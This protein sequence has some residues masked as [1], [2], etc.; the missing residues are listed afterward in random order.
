MPNYIEINKNLLFPS[1]STVGKIVV[2]VNI[3]NQ[4]TKTD[5]NGITTIIGQDWAPYTSS[6]KVF[7]AKMT[8]GGTGAPEYSTDE[9]TLGFNPE[10]RYL[11]TANYSFN[12][13]Q[14][15]DPNKI[16][17]FIYP[18]LS[19][20]ILSTYEVDAQQYNFYDSTFDSNPGGT[21]NSQVRALASQPDGKVIVGGTF[22][23]YGGLDLYRIAR[24]DYNGLVD[25]SFIY[26]GEGGF[27]DRVRKIVVQ[28]DGKILVGGDFNSYND[29]TLEITTGCPGIARLTSDGHFDLDFTIGSGFTSTGY[30]GNVYD[31]V[32]QPDGK[33]LVGGW[34][35]SY[36]GTTAN[37][38]IRLDASGSEDTTFNSG[39]GFSNVNTNSNY[40]RVSSI[41]LQPDGKITCAGQFDTY[42]N[43]YA[44][45]CA[46]IIKLNSSG[47]VDTTFYNNIG[48]GFGNDWVNVARLQDDGKI[49]VGL[50][51]NNAPIEYNGTSIEYLTRLNSNGTLDTDF[52]DIIVY[53]GN[54]NGPVNDT[55]ILTSGQIVSAGGFTVGGGNGF[56]NKVSTN[57]YLISTYNNGFDS[58]CYVLE[59]QSYGRIL[60]GGDFTYFQPMSIYGASVTRLARIYSSIDVV[61]TAR[62]N[63]GSEGNDQLN[64]TPVEI[65]Q[66][67]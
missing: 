13:S 23:Q 3:A 47:S 66:Y 1:A 60:V 67:I 14:S 18:N 9:N 38:I 11:T 42:T 62:N 49:V 28:D 17:P 61:L 55:K 46:G 16:V 64:N 27:N 37:R 32:V 52:N 10:W 22:T 31:I 40:D 53:E 6:Y 15:V 33:I 57:G 59:P 39:N 65:R 41:A 5:S 43:G 45:S 63:D 56:I 29:S 35:G 48:T 19:D 50:N 7:T 4:L 8:Q 2:G 44:Y 30:G 25:P 51:A 21:F 12:F 34:F 26:G 36:N 24:L 58:T 20:N 54:F